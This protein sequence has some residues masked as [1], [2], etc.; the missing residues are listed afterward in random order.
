MPPSLQFFLFGF[1]GP[2]KNISLILSHS[3]K[4]YRIVILFLTIR[5][6]Y[7]GA[8]IVIPDDT[9]KST[10]SKE[11]DSF[12]IFQDHFYNKFQRSKMLLKCTDH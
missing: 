4:S 11:D 5:V 1:Y 7:R 10:I 6:S 8:G 12:N 9:P 3:L 2:F